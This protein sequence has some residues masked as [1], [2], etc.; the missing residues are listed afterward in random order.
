MKRLFIL[1]LALISISLVKANNGW[2]TTVS[3]ANKN[4]WSL[5][6]CHLEAYAGKLVK[7]E[8][9]NCNDIDFC[10]VVVLENKACN[11]KTYLNL[12]RESDGSWDIDRE[13]H[14]FKVNFT[15]IPLF[16]ALADA[17]CDL[18]SLTNAFK[19][20]EDSALMNLAGHYWLYKMGSAFKY[21][22]QSGVYLKDTISAKELGGLEIEFNESPWNPA[23][24]LPKLY[25]SVQIAVIT[26]AI[27]NGV[28]LNPRT[29]NTDKVQ[30]IYNQ[31]SSPTSRSALKEAMY[32][33]INIGTDVYGFTS[34]S[35]YD[36]CSPTSFFTGFTENYTVTIFVSSENIKDIQ[37]IPRSIAMKI[38]EHLTNPSQFLGYRTRI[39]FRADK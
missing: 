35:N 39:N 7:E 27:A 17:G 2:Q 10:S 24:L 25:S 28:M 21:I 1:V 16:L 26:Q 20:D 38:F 8:I 33:D 11:V 3:D 23:E 37:D 22:A 15:R 31:I 14:Y 12:T 4:V 5:I 30:K 36:Y 34:M 32:W 9:Q 18:S 29:S 13:S 19:A 6:D